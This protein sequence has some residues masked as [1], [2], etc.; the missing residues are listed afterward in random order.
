MG[1]LAGRRAHRGPRQERAARRSRGTRPAPVS[2][3][4][5]TRA[6]AVDRPRGGSGDSSASAA[7]RSS[8]AAPAPAAGR[9]APSS[10]PIAARRLGCSIE[11]RALADPGFADHRRR[12]R[13]A[14]AGSGG[15]SLDLPDLPTAA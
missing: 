11:R 6:R 2:R 9:T 8:G 15:R 10:G 12:P 13:L 5:G 7:S 14:R 3:P 4:L 1:W